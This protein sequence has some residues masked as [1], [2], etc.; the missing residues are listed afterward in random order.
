M[1]TLHFNDMTPEINLIEK[2]FGLLQIKDVAPLGFNQQLEAAKRQRLPALQFL[3]LD[4]GDMTCRAAGVVKR[5]DQSLSA[6]PFASSAA[7]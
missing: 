1:K 4:R 6:V 5:G 2:R 7:I 3:L